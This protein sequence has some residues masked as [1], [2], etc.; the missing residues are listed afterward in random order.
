[1]AESDDITLVIGLVQASSNIAF[2][3][4][5]IH[6]ASKY[7]SGWRHLNQMIFR[8]MTILRWLR[9]SIYECIVNLYNDHDKTKRMLKFQ[10]FL[11]FD[12]NK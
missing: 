5:L 11:N 10:S 2:L 7:W 6:E 3:F 9:T 4:D 1:M 8:R 12:A